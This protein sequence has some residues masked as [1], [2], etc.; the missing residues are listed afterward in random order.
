MLLRS[1]L[2]L[3]HDVLGLGEILA[4]EMRRAGLQRLNI[5]LDALSEAGF[6]RIARRGGLDRVLAGIEAAQGAGFEAVRLN[7]VSIRG[8]TDDQIVPLAQY[9][10]QQKL[11]LRFIEFMP[12]DGEQQ[13]QAEKVLDG[14]TIRRTLEEFGPLVAV[15][16]IGL[17]RPAI[18][19]EYADGKGRVGFINSVSQPFC[20][21]CNRLRL[22]ADGQV[23]NCLFSTA[24]W[25]ARVILRG[26]GSD[27]EL[28]ELVRD[29]VWAKAPA[30][31][32]GGNAFVRPDRDM[33]QIGG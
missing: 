8:L 9:A 12:L 26:D 20:D 25:D 17:S 23:R 33:Y 18:D 28:A 5:S 29:C 30:H 1:L 22:T 31:G 13:W 4:Q 19:Y 7:A 27:D 10:R 2:I 3:E 14:E 6:E 21:Q 11:E 32:I 24:E 16:P 15:E